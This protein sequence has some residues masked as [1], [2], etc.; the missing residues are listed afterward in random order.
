MEI[1]GI[2]SS[3]QGEESNNLDLAHSES[4][5]NINSKSTSRAKFSQ[6]M[7]KGIIIYRVKTIGDTIDLDD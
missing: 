7:R 1:Y 4:F 2:Y 6:I 5:F 3:W